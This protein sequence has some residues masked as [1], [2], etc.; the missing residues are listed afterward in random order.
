MND[1]QLNKLFAQARHAR[2]DT[3]RVALGMESRLLARLRA[4]R[5]AAVPWFVWAWRL[6]PVFAAVTLAIGV[7]SYRESDG[8]DWA[9]LAG[10]ATE[11][12]LVWAW[13]GE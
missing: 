7:W 9:D 10:T 3:T 8:D 6:A 13:I 1:E 5:A 12:E 2:R 4:E 11:T